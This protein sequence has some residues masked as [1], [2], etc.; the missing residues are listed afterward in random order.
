MEIVKYTGKE[1]VLKDELYPRFGCLLFFVFPWVGI[2]LLFSLTT[3]QQM[4]VISISCQRVELTQINCQVNNSK[5]LG[6]IK[7]SSTFLSQ[8][9]EAKFNYPSVTLITPRGKEVSWQGYSY[10]EMSGMAIE[11]NVFLNSSTKPFLL[12][13]Y[14][15]RWKQENLIPLAICIIFLG[16]GVLLL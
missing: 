1:L 15:L 7:D 14:D 4:G 3:L 12:T 2:S 10:S 6:L 9:I 13:Q 11:I 16:I 8:V 5:Y